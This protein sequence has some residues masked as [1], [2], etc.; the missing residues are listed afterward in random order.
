[1]S[2]SASTSRT[3]TAT[4]SG[5]TTPGTSVPPQSAS[6]STAKPRPVPKAMQRR[7]Q[8]PLLT[9]ES[10][11]KSPAGTAGSASA[12][13]PRT[14]HPASFSSKGNPQHSSNP[15]T[16]KGGSHNNEGNKGEKQKAEPYKK[17]S[18][19]WYLDGSVLVQV[20]G[21]RYKL[22]R[23][24]DGRDWEVLVGALDGVVYV[25]AF[26]PPC[27]LVLTSPPLLSFSLPPDIGHTSRPRPLPP[28]SPPSSAPRM[29]SV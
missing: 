26:I 12:S 9:K 27:K 23:V 2:T 8:R 22:H 13:K 1:M 7:A 29:L 19:H 10:V 16:S 11:R 21:V 14:S 20:D 6:A 17:R 3:A 24:V 28:R 25:L 5:S 15:S 18:M 4:A